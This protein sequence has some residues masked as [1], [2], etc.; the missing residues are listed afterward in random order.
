ME[1]SV[2]CCSDAGGGEDSFLAT[3]PSGAGRRK[4]SSPA[5]LLGPRPISRRFSNVGLTARKFSHS[6][7]WGSSA[8]QAEIVSQGRALCI[9]YIRSRLKRSG[10]FTKK[11]GLQR[12]RSTA[13]LPGGYVVRQVLPDLIS[14]GTELERLHPKVYTNV[15]RQISTLP[16]GAAASEKA[17]ASGLAAV[18]KEL[19]QGPITWATVVSLYAIAGGL[20]VD[21]VRGGHPEY[22][23]SL[24][25]AMS[26]AVE[27]EL[28]SWIAD[29]G[30]WP[31]LCSYCKPLS[32][33]VSLSAF[34]ALL[35]ALIGTAFL[36]I[37]LLR[38]FGRFKAYIH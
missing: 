21:C 36:I 23:T 27:E 19:C 7:G 13:S 2:L 12:L 5:T 34:L 11:C 37:L 29:N 33:E 18:A 22:M 31:G 8:A 32:P 38:L 17:L 14:I 25:E 24:V 26:V 3:R 35:G 4:L 9:Q 6:L 20:A 10:V 15:G 16:G 30:G 28:A 1:T